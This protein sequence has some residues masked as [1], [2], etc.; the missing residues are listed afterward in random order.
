MVAGTKFVSEAGKNM[1]VSKALYGSNSSGAAFR[2]LLA[3]TLDAMGYRP[4]YAEPDL[5]LCP[6]VKPEGFEYYEY[7]LCYVY[8]VLCISHNLQKSMKSIQENFKLKDDKIE[9][10]DVY[11]G[12]TLAKMKLESCKY[13]WTIMPEKYV[14]AAV[15]NFEE[16]LA[17][18][19]KI[20]PSKCVN[21][22]QEIMYLGWSIIRI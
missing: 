17:R 12:A 2:A 9:L 11:L 3:E 6:A 5:W 20:F 21:R 19:G 10:P 7:I 14:K 1:L 22:S 15:K 18:S 13:C 4:R 8:N 16:D